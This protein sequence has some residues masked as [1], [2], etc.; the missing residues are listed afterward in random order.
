MTPGSISLLRMPAGSPI[1]ASRGK[2]VR[3]ITR[4]QFAFAASAVASAAFAGPRDLARATEP[5]TV[6]FARIEKEARGRLGVAVLDTQSGMQSGY[7]ENERFPMC[8]TF[9]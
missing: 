4:R 5:L 9:K 1:A 8:S 7:R 3:M 6:A 2:G